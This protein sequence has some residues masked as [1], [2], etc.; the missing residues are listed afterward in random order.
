MGNYDKWLNCEEY[1]CF[2]IENNK[3]FCDSCQKKYAKK[4]KQV[5]Y[6]NRGAEPMKKEHL[7]NHLRTLRHLR[8]KLQKKNNN[9]SQ[10]QNNISKVNNDK[11]TKK[12]VIQ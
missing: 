4:E 11:I 10:K 12:E 2:K 9:N 8:S 1:S 5:T 7:I 3:I 6:A